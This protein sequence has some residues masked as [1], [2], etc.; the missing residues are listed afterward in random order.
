MDGITTFS[1]NE[2]RSEVPEMAV[3]LFTIATIYLQYVLRIIS[4]PSVVAS[5]HEQVHSQVRNSY[6]ARGHMRTS[7]FDAQAKIAIK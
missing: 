6:I 2:C 7:H 4:R 1:L 3:Y 5:S